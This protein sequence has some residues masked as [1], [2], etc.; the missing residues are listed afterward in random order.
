MDLNFD[1]DRRANV[2]ALDDGAA[3]PEIAGEVGSLQRV[4]ENAGARIADQRMIGRF[5][6][7][8]L[9]QLVEIVDVF[10][11]TGAVDGFAGKCP[12]RRALRRGTG[13]EADDGR[14]DVFSGDGV[15]NEEN[16]RGPGF[17]KIIDIADYRICFGGVRQQRVWIR[18]RRRY[19]NLRGWAGF[20]LFRGAMMRKQADADKDQEGED[21][22]RDAQEKQRIEA[23]RA[24]SGGRKRGLNAGN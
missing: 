23:W 14:G 21:Q 22:S 17:G 6:A 24:S 18:R 11:L 4:V 19:F 10:Q 16:S 1:A 15:A 13:G 9:A 7:V 3:N 12:I 20:G 2:A 5:V 8:V